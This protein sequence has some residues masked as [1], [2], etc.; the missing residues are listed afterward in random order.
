[1]GL[2]LP[3]DYAMAPEGSAGGILSGNGTIASNVSV[4]NGSILSPG[5]SP[6]TL[7]F[8][9]LIEFGPSGRYTWEIND[10]DAGA[11]VFPGWDLI[12]I[13]DQLMITATAGAKYQIDVTSLTLGDAAGAV[14]DFDPAQS[15]DWIIATAGGGITGFDA[16]FFQVNTSSFANSFDGSFSL[17][18]SGNG[19]FLHYSAVPEPGSCTLA[20]VGWYVRRRRRLA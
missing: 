18:Q 1:M 13:A 17:V 20:A 6:G 4:S 9:G 11:G 7:H 8:T 16:N 2:I 19:L 3:P 5:N 12:D 14:H 10:V 15:Y